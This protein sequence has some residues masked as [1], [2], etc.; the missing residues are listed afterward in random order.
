MTVISRR[1][2][3]NRAHLGSVMSL[4]Q[5]ASVTNKPV[6][7][8]KILYLEISFVSDTYVGG[9]GIVLLG[10]KIMN[11]PHLP[12][13]FCQKY[14]K[15]RNCFRQKYPKIRN[16]FCQKYPKIRNCF[17]RKYPKIRNC[18]M[19]VPEFGHLVHVS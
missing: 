3:F 15:I 18:L 17:R 1:L 6:S 11:F 12:K 16:C 5:K 4:F 2:N 10:A 8:Q 7:A 14:P 9:I 19:R 13:C